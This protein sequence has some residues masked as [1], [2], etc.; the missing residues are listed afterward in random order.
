[1]KHRERAV[2]RL[3]KHGI[4]RRKRPAADCGRRRRDL[5]FERRVAASQVSIY[6]FKS[7]L[8]TLGSLRKFRSVGCLPR[9]QLLCD[10]HTGGSCHGFKTTDEVDINRAT[11]PFVVSSQFRNPAV[12]GLALLCCGG[13]D[14]L[15]LR[16]T[17][18]C[19]KSSMFCKRTEKTHSNIT[20]H[21]S[22]PAVR[23]YVT[24][25][26]AD[27]ESSLLLDSSSSIQTPR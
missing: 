1:M 27:K 21:G 7:P 17:I 16:E 19:C 13:S 4:G 8:S 26:S 22:G 6:P 10:G 11:P 5:G 12:L 25:C 15:Y 18:Y 24:W 9:C 23:C 14:A 2:S 20:E 3:S